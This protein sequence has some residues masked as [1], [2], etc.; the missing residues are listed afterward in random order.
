[1]RFR[2]QH[3]AQQR[4]MM[5]DCRPCWWNEGD[6]CYVEPCQRDERGYSNKLAINR[7]EKYWNKRKAPRNRNTKRNVDHNIRGQQMSKYFM[8]QYDV[9]LNYQKDDGYW[10]IGHIENIF[11]KVKHG[12]NE[13]NNHDEAKRIALHKFPKSKIVSV[14]YC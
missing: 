6:Y 7:C 1:M 14:T 8:E 2:S 9:K 12:V 10:V 11:I 4:T 3:Y 5:S 13:K